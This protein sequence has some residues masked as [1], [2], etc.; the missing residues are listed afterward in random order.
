MKTSRIQLQN[1]RLNMYRSTI[2]RSVVPLLWVFM[3]LV[4]CGNWVRSQVN[5]GLQFRLSQSGVDY[6]AEVAVDMLYAEAQKIQISDLSGSKSVVIGTVEYAVTNIRV[7][8]HQQY[9]F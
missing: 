2:S 6:A 3:A 1:L 8:R 4:V 5:P 7:C 9:C